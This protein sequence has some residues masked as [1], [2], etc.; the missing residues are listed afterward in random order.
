MPRIAAFYGIV[1]AMYFA[2][3]EPP[4]FHVIHGEYRALVAIEPIR[5]LAGSLPRRAESMVFEWA[6]RHQTELAED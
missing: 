4:H 2:D 1:I 6:A 3:H 5:V